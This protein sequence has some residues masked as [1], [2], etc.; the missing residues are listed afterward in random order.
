MRGPLH[1]TAHSTKPRWRRAACWPAVAVVGAWRGPRVVRVSEDRSVEGASSAVHKGERCVQTVQ[2]ELPASSAGVWLRKP[3]SIAMLHV[4]KED[5]A[6]QARLCVK[7]GAGYHP[8]TIS[9]R[10]FFLGEGGSGAELFS[11]AC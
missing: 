10:Q 1:D 8:Q 3:R 6:G 7:S 2:L 4:F 5:F 11:V 9:D